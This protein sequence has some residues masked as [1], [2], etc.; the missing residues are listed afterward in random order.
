MLTIIK[1]KY[2][3]EEDIQ[4]LGENNEELFSFKMQLTSDELKQLEDAMFNKDTI[5]MANKIKSFENKEL[6]EEEQDNILNMAEEMNNKAENLIE[7]LCF[8]ENKDKFIELGGES[9]FIEMKEVISDYLTNFFMKKRI[10]RTNTINSD[11][12]KITKN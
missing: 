8:K 4:L 6:S 1:K 11:L 9:K 3:I 2:E 10:A 12:A 7:K 5:K